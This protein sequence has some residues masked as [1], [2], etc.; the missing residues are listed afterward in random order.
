MSESTLEPLQSVA[1]SLPEPIIIGFGVAFVLGLIVW[2]LGRA[3]AKPA[4]VLSGLG[5]GA[6]GGAVLADAVAAQGITVL[7]VVV[8]A[9]LAGAILSAML[10]RL[11]VGVV[12]AVL[13]ALLVPAG[14]LVWEGTPT[15]VAAAT[16]TQPS[17]EAQIDAPERA[18]SDERLAEPERE[19]S[20]NDPEPSESPSASDV[21][22]ATQPSDAIDLAVRALRGLYQQQAEAVADWWAQLDAT[23]KERIGYGSAGGALIGLVLGLIAPFSAAALES[24]VAGA[25]LMFFPGR[26]LL[27]QWFPEQTGW[28]PQSPR[29]VVLSLVALTLLGFWLQ[30]M[31]SG[32]NK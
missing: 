6:I 15:P 2:L 14:M 27:A 29:M 10:F 30:S 12:G 4:C 8:G 31:L 20:E 11:W 18:P 17:D 9:A 7:V 28:L 3:L 19:S 5:L 1:A 32:K 23:T 26:A 22:A 13:L 16:A 21:V 24:A 25:I